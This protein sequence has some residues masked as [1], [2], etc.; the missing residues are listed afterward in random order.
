MQHADS[1]R[2]PQATTDMK[3]RI[4]ALKAQGTSIDTIIELL[5]DRSHRAEVEGQG[6]RYEF[7]DQ[8][9]PDGQRRQPG[10]R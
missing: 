7:T 9:R 10:G 4:A 1:G 2:G 8:V 5:W 6:Y 3:A